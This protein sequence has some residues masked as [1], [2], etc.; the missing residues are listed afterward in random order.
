MVAARM[1]HDVYGS[2]VK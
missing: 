1:T 2:I